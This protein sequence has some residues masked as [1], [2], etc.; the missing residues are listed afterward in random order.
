MSDPLPP[1]CPRERQVISPELLARGH[2]LGCWHAV[3]RDLAVE[4][5][6]LLTQQ[7]R[8]SAA[9]RSPFDFSPVIRRHELTLT[10]PTLDQPKSDASNLLESLN[11][12]AQT[13]YSTYDWRV[14]QRLPNTL[15]EANWGVAAYG[16]GSE[17]VAVRPCD[18][19]SPPLGIAVDLGTTNIAA[20]LFDLK[21][22]TQ[23]DAVGAANPAGAYG[24]DILS[25]LSFSQRDPSNAAHLQQ[26]LAKTLNLIAAQVTNAHGY[27]P[28]DLDEMVVVGNSGMHHLFCNLVSRQLVNAPYVL[29]TREG[30]SVKARELGLSLSTGAYVYLPPLI[31]GFIGSDL[32][33]VVLSARIDQAR[34]VLLALDIGTNTELLLSVS[35]DLYCCSCASGPA[36]EGAALRFGCMAVPGAIDRV[37]I[38]R[39]SGTLKCHTIHGK[40]AIGICGSGIIDALACMIRMGI[41]NSSGR[42]QVEAANVRSRPNGNHELVLVPAEKTELGED[43]TISQ[44]DIREIQ[45]AKGAIRGGIETLMSDHHLAIEEISEVLIAGAFGNH[46]R[47]KSALDIGLLPPIHPSRIRQIGN[48]AGTGAGLMLVSLSERTLAEKISKQIRYV[49]L[50]IHPQFKRFF[51]SAQLFPGY[52]HG[53]DNS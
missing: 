37:E 50:S 15:R 19:T 27:Q 18:Y 16:R 41:I 17:V 40:P 31:G 22:G 43:L 52:R 33:G 9:E 3:D 44:A 12:T 42:L 30:V 8:K 2:R 47:I 26:V 6:A 39:A 4:V 38:D 13:G 34:G 53:E 46:L 29:A 24:A 49:E 20:Y 7:R 35:G 11:E 36:L 21:T 45:L 14:L 1:P 5:L 23:M 51:Y 48:A 25:R 32:L 28:E 10:P